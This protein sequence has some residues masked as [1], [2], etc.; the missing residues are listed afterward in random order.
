[1]LQASPADSSGQRDCLRMRDM[2]AGVQAG[3]Q[4][5]YGLNLFKVASIPL[6]TDLE[7]N[8]CCNTDLRQKSF[9]WI[10]ANRSG[11][12][13]QRLL[14]RPVTINGAVMPK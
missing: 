3:C 4:S 8:K 11:L 9:H 5:I 12:Q 10:V 6:H 1:M 14:W 13:R 2:S 7:S